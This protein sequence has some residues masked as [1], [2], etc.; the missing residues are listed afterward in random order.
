MKISISALASLRALIEIKQSMLRIVCGRSD[1]APARSANRH[2]ADARRWNVSL[3]Q[4]RR[5][6]T[7]VLAAPPINESEEEEPYD[8][9]EMPV[10]SRGL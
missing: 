9:D 5:T 6:Q 7:R 3:S 1:G 4:D 10:P 8:I 2:K